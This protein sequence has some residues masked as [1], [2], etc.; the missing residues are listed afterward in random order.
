MRPALF[1]AALLFAN[2]V[3]AA[4]K[5]SVFEAYGELFAIFILLAVVVFVISR[6]PTVEE[7]N[8]SPAFKRRRVM[9]WLPLGLT[10]AFLYMGRYNLKV[11]K[12]NL[13]KCR[14]PPVAHS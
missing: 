10:Y 12:F 6:L 3:F 8:H 1:I 5:A 7:V 9:N 11:S 14:M 4:E 13:R 2:D